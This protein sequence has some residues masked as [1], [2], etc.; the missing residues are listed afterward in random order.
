MDLAIVS[1]NVAMLANFAKAKL[2]VIGPGS[3]GWN[4]IYS[5]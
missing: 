5:A 2:I 1:A 3:C 4:K